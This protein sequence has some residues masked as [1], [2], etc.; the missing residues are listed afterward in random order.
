MIRSMGLISRWKPQQWKPTSAQKEMAAR[1]A[2]SFVGSRVRTL[3]DGT[4]DLRT[5]EH[6]EVRRYLVLQDGTAT[7]I[8]SRPTSAAYKWMEFARPVAKVV[9]IAAIV[10]LIVTQAVHFHEETLG[11]RLPP[12]SPP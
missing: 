1:L 7:V 5:I 3:S 11:G 12:C 9:A 4:T 8:E 10:W 2:D 6:G